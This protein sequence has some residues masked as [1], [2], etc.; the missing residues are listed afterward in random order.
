MKPRII[1]IHG[2]QTMTWKF[3][4]IPWFK[5]EL[6]KLGFETVFETMPDSI[7]A[8]AKYWL[9]FLQDYLQACENDVLVGWSSGATASMRYA[10]QY[11]IKGSVLI[12]PS[13]TDLGDDLEKQSGYF[14][15]PWNWGKIKANQE[16]IALFYSENDPYIPAAEFKHIASQIQ[17]EEFNLPNR[18][19]FIEDE[20]FPELLNYIIKKYTQ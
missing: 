10:E 19:H 4:W 18:Q 7:I 2:N 1:F 12:A 3:G 9:P 20:T 14:D 16:S 11:K 13:H 8:R 17:P 15:T 6:Q 5:N